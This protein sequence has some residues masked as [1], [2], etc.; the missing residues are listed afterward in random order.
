VRSR[1]CL[2][3]KALEKY[4]VVITTFQT[5]ASEHG[6]YAP[7]PKPESSS[8][9]SDDDVPLSR[10]IKKAVHKKGPGSPLFQIKWLR[11]VIG[12]LGSTFQWSQK[13]TS[14]RSSKYQES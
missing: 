5:L 3:A 4:D 10:P 11:V 13:L 7:K 2:V 1:S 8:S 9:S 6:A 12:E 14:R